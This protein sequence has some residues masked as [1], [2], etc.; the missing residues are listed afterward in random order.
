M[1]RRAPA[2]LSGPAVLGV[3]LVAL[4]AGALWLN[5]Y[6]LGQAGGVPVRMNRLTGEVIGCGAQGCVAIIPAGEPQLKTSA[7]PAAPPQPAAPP[8]A[9]SPAA[10]PKAAPA[11]KAAS[12]P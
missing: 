3:L 4:A 10:E 9:A 6:E 8:A 2:P 1:A 12:K 5:R 7:P 11:E